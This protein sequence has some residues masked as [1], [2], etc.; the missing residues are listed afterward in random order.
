M[1]TV[2][3]VQSDNNV[4][5][6]HAL[7]LVSFGTLP[8]S[9]TEPVEQ[10]TPTK[11]LGDCQLVSCQI[12]GHWDNL[13]TEYLS[14]QNWA[15]GVVP[16]LLPGLQTLY[17]MFVHSKGEFVQCVQI[18]TLYTMFVHSK[19][20]F[21]QCVQLCTHGVFTWNSCRAA[22]GA[23]ESRLELAMEDYSGTGKMSSLF[24]YNIVDYLSNKP[25]SGF[26]MS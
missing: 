3:T 21:V 9:K 25:A 5:T 4:I 19:G 23:F 13:V 14:V 1:H 26:I 2:T 22:H 16:K 12:T 6:S 10:A 15:P 18:C 8:L 7:H 20:E 11:T 17:T 24:S